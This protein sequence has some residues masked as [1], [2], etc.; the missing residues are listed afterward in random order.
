MEQW[1]LCLKAMSDGLIVENVFR[2]K[3]YRNLSSSY[4]QLGEIKQAIVYYREAALM[5][6]KTQEDTDLA[7]ICWGL[8]ACY[9]SEKNYPQAKISLLKGINL[10]KKLGDEKA[11][12]ALDNL[13]GCVLLDNDEATEAERYLLEANEISVRI[14]D[15]LILAYNY[16][17]LA[18]LY[19]ELRLWD[20]AQ[21]NS[22]LAI[23]NTRQAGDKLNLGLSLSQLA[24]VKLEIDEKEKAL[25]LF[26]EA[27]N[28][29][30]TTDSKE[31]TKKV[32]LRYAEAL[33]DMGRMQEAAQKYRKANELVKV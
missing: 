4:Y 30:E 28:V 18:Y 26:E 2:M 3:I 22:K 29:L 8:G 20:K 14:N 11:V 13:L 9:R 15:D 16:V 10:Y 21:S 33:E 25:K 31:A 27:I 32:Y 17:N 5:A 6:E 23:R 12:A 1:K 19:Y 24:R 7:S